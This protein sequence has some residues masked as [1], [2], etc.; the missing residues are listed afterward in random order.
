MRFRRLT[1]SPI[2]SGPPAK[3]TG[4][5]SFRRSAK[6]SRA[7][8]A[9]RGT[10]LS[11]RRNRS[12]APRVC[13]L[14]KTQAPRASSLRLLRIRLP[15][16]WQRGLCSATRSQQPPL[17]RDLLHPVLSRWRMPR[18][19]IHNPR[20]TNTYAI[21]IRNSPIMSTYKIS[22]LELIQNEHLRKRGERVAT[23][24][25]AAGGPPTRRPAAARCWPRTARLTW[26]W[27]W[28]RVSDPR[29]SPTPTCAKGGAC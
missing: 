6:S 7:N 21:M 24:V 4:R 5:M 29:A 2:R 23:A 27:I 16:P 9:S 25:A 1:K 3:V 18:R 11:P 10:S 20:G 12:R 17:T 19:Q 28:Q 15:L 13:R 14:P 8:I 22:R 26:V